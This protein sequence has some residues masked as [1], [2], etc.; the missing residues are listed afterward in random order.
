MLDVVR[1]ILRLPPRRTQNGKPIEW[2]D[3]IQLTACLLLLEVARADGQLGAQE[4]HCIAVGLRAQFGLTVTDVTELVAVAEETRKEA[5]DLCQ[6]TS[7]IA[8]RYSTTQRTVLA[9]M[10]FDVAHSDGSVTW[11]EDY[12]MR[13]ISSLLR[14]DPEAA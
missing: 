8:E 13:K 6:L 2:K 11:R 12:L 4:S 5:V 1:R 7:C 3:D 14:L 10:L 9:Q